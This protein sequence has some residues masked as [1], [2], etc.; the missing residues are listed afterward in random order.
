MPAP[1]PPGGRLAIGSP[2]HYRW[3]HGIV[4]C[5]LVLNLLDAVFTLLWVGGG[6]AR[7]AN[8]FIAELVDENPVGFVVMKT[9]LVAGGSWLLWER[10]EHPYAVIGIFAGF[11]AYYAVLVH[12]IQ[13]ASGLVG[14]LLRA[15]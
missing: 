8:P 15:V 11:V 4:K 7:E 3:L 14:H 1:S 5:V 2:Q 13:Y 12:H 9:A 10:R 6:L